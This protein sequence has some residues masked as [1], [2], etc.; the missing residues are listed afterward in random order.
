M[1]LEE[2][3]L[4]VAPGPDPLESVLAR[5]ESM[6]GRVTESTER[7]TEEIARL[8]ERLDNR[9][10]DMAK[11]FVDHAHVPIVSDAAEH[12]M[13]IAEELPVA[14]GVVQAGEHAAEGVNESGTAVIE[15]A[16]PAPTEPKAAKR[17][18]YS[19]RMR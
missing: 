15:H 9:L 12:T 3:I 19:L 2:P 11:A 8:A 16:P 5:I 6:T 17:R 7:N 13:H 10:D 1:S 18:Y 14:G 4:H